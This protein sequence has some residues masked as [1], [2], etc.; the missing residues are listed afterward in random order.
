MSQ[1]DNFQFST[2]NSQLTRCAA[3]NFQFSTFNSL[4]LLLA[5]A[6]EA[7]KAPHNVGAV[8]ANNLAVGETGF[9][10]IGCLVVGQTAVGGEYHF[11]VGNIE[12]GVAG[13]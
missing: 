9:E 12:V 4:G 8:N 11:P 2:F 6:V 13:G 1:P 7:A 10:D 5:E 3:A